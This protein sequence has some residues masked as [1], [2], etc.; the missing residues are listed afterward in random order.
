M[1]LP[2]QCI[3]EQ[4]PQDTPGD[5]GGLPGWAGPGRLICI[6]DTSLTTCTCRPGP[7]HRILHLTEWSAVNSPL[8]SCSSRVHS[9]FLWEA[10]TALHSFLKE[11]WGRASPLPQCLGCL[12]GQ[13]SLMNE[14]HVPWRCVT[15]LLQWE[16]Q[17]SHRGSFQPPPPVS[18]LSLGPQPADF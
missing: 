8:I 14:G 5:S 7:A 4:C 2:C 17:F 18:V 13:F 12:Q 10:A 9:H 1:E 11:I 16:P 15:D 3:W 6:Q